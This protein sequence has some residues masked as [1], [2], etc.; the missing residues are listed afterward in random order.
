ML[1]YTNNSDIHSIG[2]KN[3]DELAS[4]AYYLENDHCNVSE[5]TEIKK[6]FS[7]ESE[8]YE[9]KNDIKEIK[10]TIKE[11]LEMMKSVYEFEDA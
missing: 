11:L 9:M 4:N 5:K 6:T 3:A 7:I 8:I 10:A 1:S 2:N